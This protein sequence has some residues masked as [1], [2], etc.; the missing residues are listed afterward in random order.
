MKK[1]NKTYINKNILRYDQEINLLE[2]KLKYIKELKDFY[3]KKQSNYGRA[4]KREK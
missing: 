4:N 2:Q 1:L 3:L